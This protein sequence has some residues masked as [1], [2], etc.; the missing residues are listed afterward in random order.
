MLFIKSLVIVCYSSVVFWV[1]LP[2]QIIPPPEIFQVTC[3]NHLRCLEW[4]FYIQHMTYKLYP[5]QYIYL[6]KW[7]PRWQNVQLPISIFAKKNYFEFIIIHILKANDLT[8]SFVPIFTLS[9]HYLFKMKSILDSQC[10]D[11]SQHYQFVKINNKTWEF[12][13]R[14]P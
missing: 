4:R 7:L 11:T 2:S 14:S 8:Y 1:I 9:K 12:R 10:R 13:S 3:W 5:W 6:L